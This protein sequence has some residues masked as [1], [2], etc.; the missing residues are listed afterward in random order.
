MTTKPKRITKPRVTRGSHSTR[1][2]YPDGTIVFQSDW[3]ALLRD[4]Q[5]AISDY[6]LS[7]LKPAVRAKA[8]TRR[9]KEKDR[10]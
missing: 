4:V 5:R 6:E 9:R 7:Q 1:T 2:Q 3:D 8:A 10:E